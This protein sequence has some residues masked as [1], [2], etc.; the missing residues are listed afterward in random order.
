MLDQNAQPPRAFHFANNELKAINTLYG[1]IMGMTSDGQINDAEINFLNLWLLD[2]DA[3]TRNFPLSAVKSRID[4]ILA[5]GIITQEERE[6]FFKTL[7]TIVGGTYTETGA[8]GG[9]STQYGIDEPDQIEFD[10]TVFC[11]T[12]AFIT[13]TRS[14]CEQLV[15]QKGARTIS[16]ITKELNYL[17]IGALASRDWI[18]SSHGRKIEKAQLYKNQGHPITI[19]HEEHWQKFVS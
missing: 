13:G 15:T 2:N 6:D 10:N 18:G 19:I 3:Y 16:N 9:N 11:F 1:L 4:A 8:T 17:V 14:K 7:S 12:G 5:D